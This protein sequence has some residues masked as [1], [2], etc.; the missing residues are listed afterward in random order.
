M[1]ANLGGVFIYSKDPKT[2][3][4]WYKE[5]LGIQY[6]YSK[7]HDTYYI[8]F[9]YKEKDTGNKAYTAWGIMK[10]KAGNPLQGIV[11]VNYRVFDLQKVID[12]LRSK[13]IEVDGPKNF[14][15]GKFAWCNDLDGNKIELWED[16]N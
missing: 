5:H 1:V 3:A 2:L 7:E 8:S 9:Y 11:A 15:E 6:D 10:R 4:E 12:H 13:G 16:T 14:P